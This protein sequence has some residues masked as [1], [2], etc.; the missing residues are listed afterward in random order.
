[1]VWLPQFYFVGRAKFSEQML[2][3]TQVEEVITQILVVSMIQRKHS[4]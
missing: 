3:G 2:E 4:L 1:M